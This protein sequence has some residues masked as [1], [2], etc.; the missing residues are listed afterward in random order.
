MNLSIARRAPSWIQFGAWA[1]CGASGALV[2]LGAFTVGPFAI[3][4]AAVFAG[5]ALIA[6]G[7]NFS[8][9]GGVAWSRSLGTGARMAQS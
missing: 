1:L 8:A 2:L 7:A 9:V 4:P 5:V 3:V 6:G